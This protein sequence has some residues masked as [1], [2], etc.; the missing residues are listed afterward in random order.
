MNVPVA[1]ETMFGILDYQNTT[2]IIVG[3]GTIHRYIGY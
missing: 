2:T 3:C 1:M